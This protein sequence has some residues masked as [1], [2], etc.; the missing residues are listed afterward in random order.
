M[1]RS[2]LVVGAGGHGRVVADA[3]LAT[4]AWHEIAF[5]D[6]QVATTQR[7]I[8]LP[9]VGS[10]ASLPGLRS[11]YHAVVVA[12]GAAAER[13][14]L[15]EHCCNLGFELPLIV[16]PTASVSRFAKLQEGCVVCAQAV[17]SAGAVLGRGCIVNTA[18]SVDHDCSLDSGVHI[19]PGARLAGNVRVGSGSW[20]GIGSCIRQG[21]VIGSGS[22]VAAGAV[23]VADV[24]SGVTV[25]GNPAREKMTK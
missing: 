23:V 14:R 1:S 16:H 15:L 8:D 4:E 10:T 2:L 19:C 22:T 6:D 9:V 3:A 5:I 12:I 18:S 11:N 25:I 7:V 24:A 21:I 17:V 20:I 13:L